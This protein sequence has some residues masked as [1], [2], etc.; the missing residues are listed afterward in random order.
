[1]GG[2]LVFPAQ[3]VGDNGHGLQFAIQITSQIHA[4]CR[5]RVHESRAAVLV[6]HAAVTGAVP[7]RQ[8]VVIAVITVPAV[9]VTNQ[10]QVVLALQPGKIVALARAQHGDLGKKWLEVLEIAF[11]DEGA[12]NEAIRLL[13]VQERLKII[14]VVIAYTV[15]RKIDVLKIQIPVVELTIAIAREQLGA[16]ALQWEDSLAADILIEFHQPAPQLGRGGG[17]LSESRDGKH[18]D[19][20]QTNSCHNSSVN[21]HRSRTASSGS[22]EKPFLFGC[23]ALVV[24]TRTP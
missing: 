22:G 1:V 4:L 12:R 19:Q 14:Q 24:F 11:R 20:Q 15:I 18:E 23:H 9:D 17:L 21:L 8:T 2:C 10:A 7:Y 3:L 5:E 13:T 6:V 16:A